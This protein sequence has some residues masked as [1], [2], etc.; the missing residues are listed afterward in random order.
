MKRPEN[1]IASCLILFQKIGEPWLY[2]EDVL[3]KQ[4]VLIAGSTQKKFK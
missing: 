4:M 2:M 3:N 1:S